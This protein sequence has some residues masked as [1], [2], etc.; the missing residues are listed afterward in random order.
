MQIVYKNIGETPLECIDR[1]SDSQKK[2]YVGRLDPMAEGL[3]LMLEDEE[4][5]NAEKYRHLNKVYEYEFAVG[6]STDTYDVLGKILQYEEKYD[7]VS[8]V[9][10][11]VRNAVSSL[12]GD[13]VLPYPPFS[14]KTVDGVALFEYAKNNL[15]GAI[16]VP[17]KEIKI[18]EHTY[19][20]VKTIAS[21]ELRKS[22]IENIKKVTGE[23]RQDEIIKLWNELPGIHL[24]VFSATICASSG[25][26]VRGVVNEIGNRISLPTVVCKIKRTKIGEWDSA[27]F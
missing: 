3:I 17:K 9:S 15:I 25:T 8:D 2:T 21:D 20:G 27:E 18:F 7:D 6:I 5:I 24:Q 22:I 16:D 19:N 11:M 10:T 26:Y 23:F 4:C 1:H 14:S 13:I 12:Q